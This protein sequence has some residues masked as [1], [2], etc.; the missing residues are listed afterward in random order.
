M[1]NEHVGQ[2]RMR[3]WSQGSPSRPTHW[4][5]G[6]SGLNPGQSLWPWNNVESQFP[7]Q[8]QAERVLSGDRSSPSSTDSSLRRRCPPGGPGTHIG[9]HECAGVLHEV[10]LALELQEKLVVLARALA[11]GHCAQEQKSEDQ[12]WDRGK[13][14]NQLQSLPV[15]ALQRGGRSR[16]PQRA[17]PI[18]HPHGARGWT[19]R[20]PRDTYGGHHH[21]PESRCP[22]PET[23]AASLLRRLNRQ[24]F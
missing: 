12:T 8:P 18:P 10:R 14:R 11:R 2:T 17:Q 1:C 15:G 7:H 20:V 22:A 13:T 16:G 19:L 9:I 23:V 24:A 6:I 21:R 3:Y 5:L 4:F